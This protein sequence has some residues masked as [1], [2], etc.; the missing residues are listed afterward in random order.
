MAIAEKQPQKLTLEQRQ[1][2]RKAAKAHRAVAKAIA[3]PSAD[4]K[5]ITEAP[6]G[7]QT[8]ML[9]NGFAYGYS[10]FTGLISE[11]II[12]GLNNV[13]ITADRQHVYVQNPIYFNFSSEENWI[14]GDIK[15]DE[16]TFTFPQ[17]IA[18]TIYTDD[19]GNIEE[20]YYDYALICE[21]VMENEETEEGWYYPRENQT[22]KFKLEADGTLTCLEEDVML[23]MCNY[24]DGE[25]LDEGEEPH[26]SWQGNGD[27]INNL[28]PNTYKAVEAPEGLEFTEWQLI[29]GISS[30]PVNVA[31]LGDDI[32]I[33]RLFKSMKK[34]VVKG[35]VDGDKVTFENGQ[36]LGEYWSGGSLAFFDTG[37]I[38]SEGLFDLTE[39][40]TFNFDREKNV[41]SSEDAFCI[42]VA[43][44]KV[45]YYDK[46]EKPYIC[47]PNP[48]FTVGKLLTPA[49]YNFYEEDEEYDFDA[50]FYFNLATVD[51]SKNILP[52]E[53][54]GYQVIMDDEIFTF[55][56]DEYELPVG[57][58]ETT[59]IPYD[60]V[61]EDTDDFDSYGTRHGFIFH[62]R[63]FQNLGVREVYTDAN[64]NNVFS[65]VLWAPG[66]EG[67]FS[68]V[69]SNFVERTV[70]SKTFYNLS[71]VRVANPEKGVYI[72][73]TSYTDGTSTARK[74]VVK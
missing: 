63:G 24:F 64:G 18:E 14:V 7:T 4:D 20:A 30:R 74:V 57:V 8:V 41:L 59:I 68:G 31:F 34:A 49:L 61:S 60:Y 54:L 10:W 47:I 39:S 2:Q 35:T 12:N 46:V 70:A 51:A 55:Y 44:D 71:G 48:D 56:N 1:Q 33:K 67:T 65:D 38:N 40:M 32:Y 50:E 28:T 42:S 5:V 52:T 43:P 72:L 66:F 17:L 25:D 58:E 9:K 15:G 62:T 27:F 73:R 16:V 21:F 36:C 19:E 11:T 23:A 69:A 45:L 6:E 3:G 13:V 22:L 29:S 26:W 53:R 37:V